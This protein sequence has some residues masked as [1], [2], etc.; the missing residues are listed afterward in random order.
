[1]VELVVQMYFELK[2]FRDNCV[3]L[4]ELQEAFSAIPWL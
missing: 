2:I 1:M 3:R 4:L